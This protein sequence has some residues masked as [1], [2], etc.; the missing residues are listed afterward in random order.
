VNDHDVTAAL[1]RLIEPLEDEVG[2]WDDVLRRAAEP[3]PVHW[4]EVL[5]GAGPVRD[6]GPA[7]EPTRDR[8]GRRRHRR[9][10]IVLAAAALVVTVGTA[11]AFGTVRDALFGTVKP[12]VRGTQ[13]QSV[14]GIRFSLKVPRAHPPSSWP[15]G[16]GPTECTGRNAKVRCLFISKST[17]G[18]QRAEAII[19]WTGFPTG[20]EADPCTA[21]VSPAIGRSTDALVRAMARAPGTKLVGGP[22][23]LTVGGR[24]AR[25]IVLT[26]RRDLGCDPGFFFSWQP[27][28]PD[29]DCFG[30]CW[31]DTNVGDT[32]SVWIVDVDGKRLV[33]EAE[34]RQPE[35]QGYPLATQVTRA[36]VLKV[37]AEIE[38]IVGSIRFG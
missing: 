22:T 14:D 15:W 34:T 3:R 19:F 29:G 27:S 33:I 20:G 18:G 26:V 7:L 4:D 10:V 1:E 16:N 25:Q 6:P 30:A 28:A 32:I 21:F 35:S 37:E 31:L 8:E 2:S 17:V 5:D 24:P 9:R 11:T 13:W 23:R 38:T 36:D 12:F